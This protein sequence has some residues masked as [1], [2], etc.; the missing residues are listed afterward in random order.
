MQC[1][2]HFLGLNNIGNLYQVN[3]Y[4]SEVSVDLS[5]YQDLS[6]SKKSIIRKSLSL[7]KCMSYRNTVNPGKG[8][9][10]KPKRAV[11]LEGPFPS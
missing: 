3:N 8:H 6:T 2:T 4:F 5:Y 1:K 10:T 11:K 7:K 9:V